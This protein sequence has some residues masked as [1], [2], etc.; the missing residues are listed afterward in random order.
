MG[1]LTRAVREALDGMGIEYA[2]GYAA[3]DHRVNEDDT[4][5]VGGIAIEE[6]GSG[7]FAVFDVPLCV[8]VRML[9]AMCGR[10]GSEAEVE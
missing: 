9:P 10:A 4:T 8:L 3:C 2:E 6:D 5:Q 7:T 1:N